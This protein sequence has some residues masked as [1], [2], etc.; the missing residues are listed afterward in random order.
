MNIKQMTAEQ[1]ARY[2]MNKGLKCYCV[3]RKWYVLWIPWAKKAI[4][5]G[6]TKT[7]KRFFGL[8]GGKF[9][10]DFVRYCT[11]NIESLEVPGWIELQFPMPMPASGERHPE[12]NDMMK[13]TQTI[14]EH[15]NV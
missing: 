8:P 2:L 7:I 4:D 12:H 13:W 15:M 11:L 9:T 10:S 5:L 14:L 1:M 6:K 3:A